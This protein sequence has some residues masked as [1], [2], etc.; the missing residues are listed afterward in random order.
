M[1]SCSSRSRTPRQDPKANDSEALRW[2]A[3][4]GHKECVELLLPVSDFKANDSEAL[5]WAALSGHKEIV[6]LLIPVSDPS[7]VAELG[8]A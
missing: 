4:R 2:A 8:I 5:R 7:V 3:D 1:S 6:A